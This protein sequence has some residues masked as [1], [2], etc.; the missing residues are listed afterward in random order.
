MHIPKT[1]GTSIHRF[2]DELG[3]SGHASPHMKA[4]EIKRYLGKQRWLHWFKAAFVRNPWDRAVSTFH[5]MK[6]HKKHPSFQSLDFEEWL[7]KTDLNK[8]PTS[9]KNV[10]QF[11]WFQGHLR[12]F[13]LIGRFET[14][15]E[16]FH[17][18]CRGYVGLSPCRFSMLHL[19][20]YWNALH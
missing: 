2:F 9:R 17:F 3:N 7:I 13:N 12:K 14:L 15:Q 20:L 4:G 8:S 6:N 11:N 10:S 1:G 19:R 5:W 18:L 16:D